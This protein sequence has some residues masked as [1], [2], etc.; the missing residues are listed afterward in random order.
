MSVPIQQSQVDSRITILIVDDDVPFCRAA[1][2]L[3]ADRGFRVVGHARTA[4]EAVVECRRLAPDGVLLDVR[5][6]DGHGVELAGTLRAVPRPPTIV[7]TSSDPG[8]VPPE[9]LRVSGASGFVPKS[10]LAR[11]DLAGLFNAEGAP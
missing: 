4:H 11:S 1:A 10:Q 8:A 5:L 7:L 9:Q 6:P 2:E 3:L